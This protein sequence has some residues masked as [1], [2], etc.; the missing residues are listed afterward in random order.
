MLWA[1]LPGES[2][3]V[4]PLRCS[5]YASVD[6]KKMGR[7]AYTVEFTVCLP[8][9]PC[10]RYHP[11]VR[12]YERWIGGL[13]PELSPA[14]IAPMVD[15]IRSKNFTHAFPGDLVTTPVLRYDTFPLPMG[16]EGRYHAQPVLLPAEKP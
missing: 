13:A 16:V 1:L 3:M 14:Q 10:T 2:P 4:F 7:L 8:T 5:I 11:D 6:S 15:P 12:E 9:A